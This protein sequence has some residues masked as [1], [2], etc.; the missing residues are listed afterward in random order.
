M[1]NLA[2]NG[3]NSRYQACSIHEGKHIVHYSILYCTHLGGDCQHYHSQDLQRKHS[4]NLKDIDS[5][6]YFDNLPG[7]G[8]SSTSPD[9]MR[10]QESME[11]VCRRK[12]ELCVEW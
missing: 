10:R 1:D 11:V 4:T 12:P 3:T 5:I 6:I 9:L 7:P 2:D 8:F